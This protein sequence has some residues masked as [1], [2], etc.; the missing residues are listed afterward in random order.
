MMPSLFSRVAHRLAFATGLSTRRA[1]RLGEM[2]ILM[3]HGVGDRSFSSEDFERVLTWLERHFELVSL[4]ELVHRTLSRLRI[5]GREV[6]LTFDDGLRNN[7]TVAYPL[8]RELGIPATFF[9]C[10]GLIQEGRWLWNHEVRARLESVEKI[11]CARLRES[12]GFEGP[13]R[14][15][16][17]VD[18]VV[19]GMKALEL[20]KRAEVEAAIRGESQDFAP[21]PV[22]RR[23]YDLLGWDEVKGLDKKLI[24]IGS[25]TLTHPIL[26]T[27][28]YAD[29]DTEIRDSKRYLER[30]LGREV[31]FFCYP[32][33]ERDAR[34]RGLVEET[35]RVAVTTVP[36]T[37]TVGADVLNLPRIGVSTTRATMAW[38]MARP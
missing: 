25:H 2:R 37:V 27:L 1:K 7:A 16:S 17:E 35:Y 32:N 30:V 13:A 12:L 33:G 9:I 28:D 19:A 4:G 36:G 24:T 10:P 38:R 18:A 3:L 26:P 15:E 8:L 34:A 6:A 31:E 23:A 5:Q 22:H 29:L 21:L 20:P 14:G 11:V